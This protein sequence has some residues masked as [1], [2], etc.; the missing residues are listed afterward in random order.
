LRKE[1]IKIHKIKRYKFIRKGF[2]DFTLVEKQ[3]IR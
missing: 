3:S 2:M 1:G